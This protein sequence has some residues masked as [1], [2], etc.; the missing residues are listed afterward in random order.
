MANVKKVQLEMLAD[1]GY[2]I[3]KDELWLLEDNDNSSFEQK[4]IKWNNTYKNIDNT[5][6][7]YVHYLSGDSMIEDV[8]F[9]VLQMEKNSEGIIIGDSEQIKTI[10][11]KIYQEELKKIKFT[12]SIQ[13]FDH[14]E[15]TYNVT[16]SI[17]VPKHELI[18]MDDI[19]HFVHK[20]QLSL[21]YTTDPISKYYNWSVGDVIRVYEYNDIT[22]Y[23]TINYSVIVS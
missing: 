13:I 14:D 18:S 3:S 17:Y 20:D 6:T 7:I 10:N 12:K 19:I 4:R 15:L 16:K 8:R 9:F 2:I 11:K 5:R 23:M 21:I 22:S 1:R